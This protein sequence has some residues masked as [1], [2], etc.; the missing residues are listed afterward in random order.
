MRALNGGINYYDKFLAKF[1]WL[2]RLINA[3]L[4]QDVNFTFTPAMEPIV[5]DI[6]KEPAKRLPGRDAVTGNSHPY[7]LYC[8]A[9][10]DGFGATLGQE[11]PD[12]SV[13][14]ILF[15]SRA[16][17]D[18]ERNWTP[19]TLNPVESFGQSNGYAVTFGRP[20]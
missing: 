18:A 15:I 13:H 1:S 6:I 5:S 2:F 11:Q 19:S 20:N 4:N 16:T 17:P 14:P 12:G 7:C 3:L 8:D 9:S 10:L